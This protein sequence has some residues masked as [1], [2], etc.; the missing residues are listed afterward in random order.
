MVFKIVEDDLD[1]KMP[2][3]KDTLR[4]GKWYKAE[5]LGVD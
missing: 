3:G 2:T 1:E 4:T 5:I